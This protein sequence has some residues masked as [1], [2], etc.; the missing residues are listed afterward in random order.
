MLR[1][2][3]QAGIAIVDVP[4]GAIR[5]INKAVAEQALLI[6]ETIKMLKPEKLRDLLVT[7]EEQLENLM[8]NLK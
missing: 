8:K 6:E 7:L 4:H 1:S 2:N 3:N 5:Y